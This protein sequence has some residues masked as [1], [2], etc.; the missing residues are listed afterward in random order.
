MHHG[1]GS[2][3]ARLLPTGFVLLPNPAT[4]HVLLGL[5]QPLAAD[6]EVRLLA[7]DGRVLHRQPLATGTA[8]LLLDLHGHAPGVYIVQLE[9]GGTRMQQRLVVE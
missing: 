9:A 6:A 8:E 5:G 1:G 7:V 2:D 4:D 3:G